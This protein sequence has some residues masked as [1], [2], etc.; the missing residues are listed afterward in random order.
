MK[1]GFFD[2][3]FGGLT[4]LRAVREVLPEY[5]YVFYGDTKHLPY[6]DKSEEEIYRLTKNGLEELFHKGV[7]LAIVACNTASAET[8]RKLQDTFLRDEYPG[9]KV[10]GVIIPTVEALVELHVKKALLI[11]TKRTAES[12]KYQKELS[13]ISPKL[14][15]V[16]VA[17]PKLVPLIE[18]GRVEE[19]LNEARAA[20]DKRVGEVDAVVLGCTHYTLLKEALRACYDI[21]IISQDEILPDKLKKYL[22]KH[23]EIET[24]LTRGGTLEVI[25]TKKTD[26]YAEIQGERVLNA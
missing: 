18:A 15:I 6:G 1:I 17:T 7:T 19:A 8:L 11:G 9:H 24:R 5:D 3:G 2:S 25:F 20:I 23:H 21:P 14:S 22:K 10:L 26:Y 13:K 4:M 12:G 16:T